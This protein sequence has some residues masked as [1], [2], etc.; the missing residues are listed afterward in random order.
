[1]TVTATVLYENVEESARLAGLQYVSDQQPGISRKRWGRGFTYFY[2]DGSRLADREQRCRIKQLSLPPSWQ[3]VWICIDPVGHLQATGRDANGRKQYRYHSDWKQLRKQLKFDRMVPFAR[4]LPDLRQQ[5]QSQ[6][7]HSGGAAASLVEKAVVVAAVVKLL[8]ETLLRVGNSQYQQENG[9]HGLT[10]LRKKHVNIE[11]DRLLFSFRGKSGVT[12]V[13]DLC[14]R[15]LTTVV[16]HCKEIPGQTLFQYLDEHGQR[17]AVDS[18]DINQ[19]LQACLSG[20]FTAKD[21]RTWGGTVAAC[22]ELATA[23][24]QCEKQPTQAINKAAKQLGNR[25]AT[26]RKYYVHPKII[27]AYESGWLKTTAESIKFD[28]TCGLSPMEQLTLA[29]IEKYER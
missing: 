17:Q 12:Q 7:H 27:E 20:P 21:F 3:D 25:A 28:R 26:C 22:R 5:V 18:G 13:R 14:N 4:R 6:I 8:D 2:P 15:R 24:T 9:S 19:Y 23:D 1:M 11:T 29:V 16:K 10:T